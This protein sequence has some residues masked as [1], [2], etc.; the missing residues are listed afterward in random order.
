MTL[1]CGIDLHS[2]NSLVSLIDNDDRVIREQRLPNELDTVVD[3]LGPY[4]SDIQGV[5]VESTYNWYWLVDGLMEQGYP[6]HLANTL[7]IQQYN[8]IKYTNDATDAR[9]LAQL[10]RLGILPTGYIYPKAMRAIRDLL[11]RRLLMV[12]QRT[13]QILSLQS[14]I[15][16]HTGQRLSALRIKQLQRAD[17]AGYFTEPAALLAAQQALQLK[18]QLDSQ[19]DAIET[20]VLA[21]CA[22]QA[23]YARLTSAPGIGKILGLTILLETGPIERFAQVGHYNKRGR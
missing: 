13:A 22:H 18:Q 12:K 17:L 15:G 16:R 21:D 3:L 1:Y 5:V 23:D 7:A 19:I 2:N 9:Y 20:Q 8:G 6:V 10:L 11:R 4:Q 14:Q